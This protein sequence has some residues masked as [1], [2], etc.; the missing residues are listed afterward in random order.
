M[1]R[2]QKHLL[3]NETEIEK[4]ARFESALK[5]LRFLA[6]VRCGRLKTQDQ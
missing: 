3:T 4:V 2:A 1:Y 6:A 5:K